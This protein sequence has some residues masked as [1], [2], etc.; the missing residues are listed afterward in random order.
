[1]KP[2]FARISK[3]DRN[4]LKGC[5]LLALSLAFGLTSLRYSMGSLA[6]TGP[7]LFPLIVSSMMGVLALIAIV[8]SLASEPI[9]LRVNVTNI[10]IIV[11]SLLSFAL[12]SKYFNMLAGTV[13]L[14]FLAATA[15]RHYSV[16]RNAMVAGGLI[17]IALFFHHV[18]GLAIPL[19]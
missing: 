13:V 15:G 16:T 6:R 5:L 8:R 17:G 4:L 7:G 19:Y 3:M 14:V 12:V 10:A 1:M 18:L 2:G 9:P 11:G